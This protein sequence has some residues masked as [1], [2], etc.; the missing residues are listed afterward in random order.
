MAMMPDEK[1]D[2]VIALLNSLVGIFQ[3]GE[4]PSFLWAFAFFLA[5]AHGFRAGSGGGAR[6][7]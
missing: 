6:E 7:L 5:F 4:F 1:L 2:Q 3:A